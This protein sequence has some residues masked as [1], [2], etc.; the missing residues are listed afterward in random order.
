MKKIEFSF[1]LL[2]LIAGCKKSTSPPK[3]NTPGQTD[4][5]ISGTVGSDD[6]THAAYWKNGTMVLLPSGGQY[7][8]AGNIIVTGNDVYVAGSLGKSMGYWKNGN[9]VSLNDT[10]NNSFSMAISGSDI[11]MTATVSDG[12]HYNGGYYKNGQYSKIAP[13][14]ITTDLLGIAVSGQDVLLGGIESSGLTPTIAKYWLNGEGHNLT[15]GTKNAFV[16][17]VSF[18][19]SDIYVLGGEF[20]ASTKHC[21]AKYWKNGV[22]HIVSDTTGVNIAT[23]IAFS[24]NDVYIAGFG[25]EGPIF[26]ATR[27]AKF[28]KNDIE[29]T[30]TDGAYDSEASWVE[31]SGTDTYVVFQEYAQGIN[32][33]AEYLKNGVRQQL[34]DGSRSAHAYAS[35][36]VSSNP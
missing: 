8:T 27:A 19:G 22:A 31:T 6:T 28:W 5:Y 24:G 25:Y 3:A 20:D 10:L 4:V 35:F 17:G 2:L 11:Y 14:T 30:I 33:V 16:F 18:S 1:L 12:V 21:I 13:D 26:S 15:D 36:I 34:T 29:T 9:F 23:H 7:S 32:Q